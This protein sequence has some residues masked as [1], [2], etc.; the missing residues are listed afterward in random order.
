MGWEA[1][2]TKDA[3]N[4]NADSLHAVYMPGQAMPAHRL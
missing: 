2:E 1:A 4:L 3:H